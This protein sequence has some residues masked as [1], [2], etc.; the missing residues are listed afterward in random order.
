MSPLV[1]RDIPGFVV[2]FASYEILLDILSAPE[3]RGNVGPLAPII[4]G[5]LAGMISWTSTFPCD[6]VKSKMQAD[7]IDGKYLYKGFTDCLIKSYR[8]GGFRGFFTGLGPTLLRAFPTNGI[9]FFVYDLVS[10]FLSEKTATT[11][12][13][14]K[15]KAEPDWNLKCTWLE[16]M[17]CTY[18]YQCEKR[19]GN[20]LR[21][22]EKAKC[23][24]ENRVFCR[25]LLDTVGWATQTIN[26]GEVSQG[27]TD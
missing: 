13:S 10:K 9:I 16:S 8:T 7:G 3:S 27:R 2:Y 19:S 24:K 25:R 5:G 22:F 4:A 12:K 18:S 6:V 20:L 15:I 26:M 14:L 21:G 17:W 23:L 11:G 1:I